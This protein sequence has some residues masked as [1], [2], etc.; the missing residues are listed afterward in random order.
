MKVILECDCDRETFERILTAQDDSFDLLDS[1]IW[2]LDYGDG[3]S[4]HNTEFGDIIITAEDYE[5]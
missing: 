2:E 4:S 1:I 5:R 3:C